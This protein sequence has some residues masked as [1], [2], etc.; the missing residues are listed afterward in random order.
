VRP[1]NSHEGGV[2]RGGPA[3]RE[4]PPWATTGRLVWFLAFAVAV[5]VLMNAGRPPLGVQLGERA[6]RDYRARVPFSSTDI[7]RT[8]A[9]REQARLNEPPVFRA[10]PELWQRA[11]REAISLIRVGDEAVIRQRLPE[12]FE[13]DRFLTLLPQLQ[14]RTNDLEQALLGL[15]DRYLAEPD[16]LT[17]ASVTE[18]LTDE[19]VLLT[20]AGERTRV[21]RSELTPLAPGQAG[22]ADSLAP[23]LE[24]LAG[25]DADLLRDALASLLVPN[26]ALDVEGTRDAAQAAAA[27]AQAPPRSIDRGRII[28]A[29]GQEVGRQHIEDLQSER[30]QYWSSWGGHVVTA[31][32]LGG[33]AIL[34]A[35][36]LAA[37]ALYAW[38]YRPELFHRRAQ[39]I[40]FILL[41]LLLVGLARLCVVHGFTPLWVPIPMLVIIMCLVYDQ[42]FGLAV[43]LFYA[44]LVRLV[45]PGADFE[46]AVLLLGGVAA[47]LLTG[48]VR[49][50]GTLIEAGLL[51]GAIQF[52]AV[53]GLGMTAIEEATEVS[54]RLWQSPL[55]GSSLAAL[56]NGFLSGFIVSGALPAIEKLFRITTDIRLLEWSDPNQPLL[57]RLLLDAPGTYHHSMIVGS[58]AADAAEA[59]GANPLLARVSAYFHDVG[60]LKKPEYFAENLPDGAPNPHDGLTPT[61]SSLIISAHPKD[62]AEMAEKY[63]VPGE[64]RDVILQSHG[65]S[66]LKYFWGKAKD[67]EPEKG[68]MKEGDFRYR[69]AKPQSKEAAIVML[70]D[71]V[72]SAARSMDSPSPGQL[73][74][75]VHEIILDRLHDGQLDESGLAITDLK[76]L[77]DNLMHGLAAVH[78]N[79]VPYPAQEKPEETEAH[80][81]KPEEE[82]G[83]EG[84]D[85]Q[86]PERS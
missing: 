11:V 79:R 51:T 15:S 17:D 29:K 52:L 69:L 6:P 28:L 80:V 37:A 40:S 53:W 44:L 84:A 86:Q 45:S 70:C 43:A 62:G 74:K 20:S 38:R 55:F 66:V 19:V 32:R 30:R 27:G 10:K 25:A 4:R 57:Q 50:R 78:H 35:I 56:A 63:G 31:L 12:D 71:A 59:V 49:T 36:L 7:E 42:R 1:S 47:A 67:R 24:G 3:G 41:A 60:K 85:K 68:Q 14:E 23:A 76:R 18:K 22:V 5:F 83:D 75:L 54:W 21:G 72:E 2:K 77:E 73:Q 46:F 8:E 9:A 39:G 61:M 34:L 16:D 13:T 64:V 33:L 81:K 65:S 26:V 58:L 48:Q 82:G